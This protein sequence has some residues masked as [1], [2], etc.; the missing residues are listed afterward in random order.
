MSSSLPDSRFTA[1]SVLSESFIPA[2]SK[3]ESKDSSTGSWAPAVNDDSQYLQV[4]FN[5]QVPIYGTIIKGSPLLNQYVTSYKVLYSFN[6]FT[7]NHLVDDTGKPQI[8]SGGFDSRTSVQSLFK[9]PIEARFVRIYPI[10]W[11]EAISLKVEILGCKPKVAVTRPTTPKTTTPLPTTT[12]APIIITTE[13]PICDDPMGVEN[14]KMHPSQ[15]TFSSYKDALVKTIEK[16]P[17]SVIKLTAEKG[18][19]PLVDSQNE[20]VMVRN[21]VLFRDI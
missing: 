1:S 14:G 11:N 10:T 19:M 16:N 3:L 20:F 17:L 21:T 15:V 5:T 8:F 2:Y 9:V 7:F 13:T 12:V 4:D 18:W 6:G